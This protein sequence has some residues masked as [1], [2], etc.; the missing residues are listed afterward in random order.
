MSLETVRTLKTTFRL[1]NLCD[2]EV[3]GDVEV[4]FHALLSLVISFFNGV[5]GVDNKHN[6]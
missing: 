6:I 4:E 3:Y 2:I 1:H 5:G